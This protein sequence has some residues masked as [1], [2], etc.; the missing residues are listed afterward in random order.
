LLNSQ[1]IEAADLE[2][3]L[4]ESSFLQNT[5]CSITVLSAL[6]DLGIGLSLDDFGTGYS[7]LSY[8]KELPVNTLKIDRSFVS[9]LPGD[10]HGRAIATT[11][12]AMAKNLDLKVVAEGVESAEQTAFLNANGCDYLQ[13]YFFSKP[14]PAKELAYF[15][16]QYRKSLGNDDTRVA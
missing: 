14:I 5:E 12:L 10:Q 4:T 9:D 13:G 16:D 2:L 6:N 7:S 1:P 15:L 3:E 8:L 11:I